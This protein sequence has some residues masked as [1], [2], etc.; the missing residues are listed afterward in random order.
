MAAGAR[1]TQG[2]ETG[3]GREVARRWGEDQANLSPKASEGEAGE[4]EDSAGG[5]GT[6]AA[7]CP[8]P[9]PGDELGLL[10]ALLSSPEGWGSGRSRGGCRAFRYRW[11]RCREA[12]KPRP[13]AL[14]PTP[15][16]HF[17]SCFKL[18]PGVDTV[19]GTCLPQ[20]EGW[21]WGRGGRSL[22]WGV[23][24]PRRG[25]WLTHGPKPPGDHSELSRGQGFLCLRSRNLPQQ[26]LGGEAGSEAAGR[27]GHGSP[28]PPEKRGH[29]ENRR[30]K[31]WESGNN[32]LSPR[33]VL[34]G[35]L[36]GGGTGSGSWP[37]GR[38][39]WMWTWCPLEL[40]PHRPCQGPGLVP[41]SVRGPGCWDLCPTHLSG[42]L[43]TGT[44][45][46]SFLG[47]C[48]PPRCWVHTPS[49]H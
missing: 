17:V 9:L 15:L 20:G 48:H 39:V 11:R 44:E 29:V 28:G 33:R 5:G 24:S 6:R 3:A 1:V 43:L 27:L 30:E 47:Q 49:S 2:A 36:A 46:P 14:P 31:T 34:G 22:S 23:S 38:T 13:C 32:G 19:H 25:G 16:A 45:A 10:P 4:T 41:P 21:G 18:E 35:G 40:D 37:G 8:Q 26:S 42:P 7:V 12:G